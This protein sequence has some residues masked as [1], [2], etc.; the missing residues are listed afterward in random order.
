MSH[1]F[2][3][4]WGKR[5]YTLL[6]LIGI[7]IFQAILFPCQGFI[8]L[9]CESI[10]SVSKS[11]SSIITLSDG[12]NIGTHAKHSTTLCLNLFTGT[13]LELI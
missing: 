10:K 11:A 6:M 8:I 13:F 5:S 3:N 7:V 12:E 1:I 2:Y 4:S 9:R